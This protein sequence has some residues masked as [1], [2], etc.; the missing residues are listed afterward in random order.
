MAARRPRIS[1]AWRP[2]AAVTTSCPSRARALRRRRPLSRARRR[3]PGRR[4]A[5]APTRLL[6]GRSAIGSTASASIGSRK[7]KRAPPSVGDSTSDRAA[8]RGHDTVADGEPNPGAGPYRL[9]GEEWL[10][11]APSDRWWDAGPIVGENRLH[12]VAGTTRGH[13]KLPRS[14]LDL[15]RVLSVD[16][17]VGEHVVQQVFLR[18]QARQASARSRVISTSAV[19]RP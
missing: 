2:L 5:A 13:G 11:D 6:R 1:S 10:E 7:L 14:D 17:Q 3:P 18:Q 4:P 12:H 9:G 15:E 8:V 19:R 16:E